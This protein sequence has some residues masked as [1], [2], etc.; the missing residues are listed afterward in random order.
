MKQ[1]RWGCRPFLLPWMLLVVAFY[2]ASRQSL[3]LIPAA[4]IFRATSRSA[5][6]AGIARDVGAAIVLAI[7]QLRPRL[8]AYVT[9]LANGGEACAKSAQIDQNISRLAQCFGMGAARCSH[10]ST[11]PVGTD[12]TL[13]A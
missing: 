8:P 2:A 4:Q 3:H 13:L 5:E 9:R 1:S 6:P 11:V 10:I 12:V 7:L